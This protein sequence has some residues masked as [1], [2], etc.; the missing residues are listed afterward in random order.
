M[1]GFKRVFAV[2]ALSFA[3]ICFTSASAL[4]GGNPNRQPLPNPPD[5][6]GPLCGAS[7]GTV[8]AHLS[9]NR[10]YIKT[11]TEK[12]GTVRLEINGFAQSTVTA[13]GKTLSFNSSGPATIT[14]HPDNTVTNIGQGHAF[15]IGP[16]GPNTG[17]LVVT[18]RI[19]VDPATG[20]VVVLSGH[21]TDVCALLS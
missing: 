13:N 2:A 5:V 15:V 18:G 4:A 12:D 21:V 8:V 7:I 16:T 10:E 20:N 11:F 17:I 9:V 1:L 14:I 6:V 3:A 19:S